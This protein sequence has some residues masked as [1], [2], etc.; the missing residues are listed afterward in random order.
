[1]DLFGTEKPKRTS[2]GKDVWEALKKRAGNKCVMCGRTEKSC[3]G[4]EKAH[5][6]ADSKG[7]TQYIPLCPS[8]HSKF[9]KGLCSNSDLTKIGVPPEKYKRFQPKKAAPKKKDIFGW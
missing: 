8:C 4:L 5:L 7:G 6:K 3:G 2:L 1:M 9:D